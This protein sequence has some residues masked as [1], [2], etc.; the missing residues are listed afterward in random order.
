MNVE[1]AAPPS[2]PRRPRTDQPHKDTPPARPAGGAGRVP[3][4]ACVGSLFTAAPESR[5]NPAA[6]GPA[7]L[8]Q[9]APALAR[10]EDG[11][12]GTYLDRGHPIGRARLEAVPG[13]PAACRAGAGAASSSGGAR[14]GQ[15]QEVRDRN[16]RGRARGSVAAGDPGQVGVHDLGGH[17]RQL[18][19]APVGGRPQNL[20]RLLVVDPVLGHQQPDCV[21][22]Y[23][24]GASPARSVAASSW[25][26]AARSAAQQNA[27]ST[28]AWLTP[29]G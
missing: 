25:A 10:I 17:R 15:G 11:S 14:A 18:D 12:Y 6:E 19:V 26:A 9:T 13:P 22:D 21:A 2:L 5:A 23:P 4:R 16:G 1:S 29:A 28:A 20:E 7:L 8:A 24:V 3:D 27:A